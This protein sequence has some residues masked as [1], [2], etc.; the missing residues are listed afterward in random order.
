MTLVI[1]VTLKPS[2]DGNFKEPVVKL[3]GFWLDNKLLIGTV[4]S[5]IYISQVSMKLSRVVHLLRK[6][7]RVITTDHLLGIYHAL[8]HRHVIYGIILWGH[9]AA[10]DD[11]LPLQNQKKALRIFALA[12]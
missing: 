7:P 6:L 9:T 4:L 12:D 8:I 2:G 3:L 5:H 11:I 1:L 10:Y